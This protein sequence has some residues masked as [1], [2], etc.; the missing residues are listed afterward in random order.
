MEG[1]KAAHFNGKAAC[2]NTVVYIYIEYI[3]IHVFFPMFSG[4]SF[5]I[6]IE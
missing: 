6:C 4:Y 5:R 1:Q 3:Y 2:Q